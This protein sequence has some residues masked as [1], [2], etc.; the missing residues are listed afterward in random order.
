MKNATE[1]K[2]KLKRSKNE[3]KWGIQQVQTH[4][5]VQQKIDQ[6]DVLTAL[7]WTNLADKAYGAALMQKD[8]E[9]I[10]YQLNL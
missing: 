2:S 7:G 4:V 6:A 8:D 5:K 3:L 1:Q 10:M 9:G